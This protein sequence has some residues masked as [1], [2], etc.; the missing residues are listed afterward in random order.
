MQQGS[1]RWNRSTHAD[2]RPVL[3]ARNRIKSALRAWFA[4][5]GFVEVDGAC[6]Q[7]S[8]GNETHLHAFATTLVNEDG[9]ELPRYLQTSPEFSMKK[10]LGAGETRI[11]AFAPSFRNRERGPLHAPEFTMLEWYRTDAPYQQLWQD[12][13]AILKTAADAVAVEAFHHHGLSCDPRASPMPLTVRDALLGNDRIGLDLNLVLTASGPNLDALKSWGRRRGGRPVG[14]W[15]TW[16]SHAIVE[17][18]RQ[19]GAPTPGLLI[20]YPAV[21]SALARPL[22]CDPRYAQ[23][24]ELFVCG[25]ELA[26]G[27]AELGD[28]IELRRRL[29]HQ[30]NERQRLYGEHYPIDKA[31]LAALGEM[32][33]ACGCALGFD[34]LV[35]LATGAQ[36]I[37]LVQ[38][39]PPC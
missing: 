12:C 3:L 19:F 28:P 22:V 27:C 34:R 14:D 1:P 5:Q 36:H 23:R 30:M 13:A 31:M 24:F 6:L 26:N 11:Y 20:E 18:T 10:L 17:A 25:V 8:P 32:P 37:E 38:W 35:M 29:Q 21:E 2:R 9:S 16:F 15:G 4:D 33:P 39:V 7:V